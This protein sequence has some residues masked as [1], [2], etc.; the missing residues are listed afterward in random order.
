MQTKTKGCITKQV[1]QSPAFFMLAGLPKP[2]AT[3]RDREYHEG[4]YQLSLLTQGFFLRIC[5]RSYKKGRL[6]DHLTTAQ[7]GSISCHLLPPV[8]IMKTY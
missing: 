7:N 5:E 2:K 1:R 4:G 6:S 8:K 3:I